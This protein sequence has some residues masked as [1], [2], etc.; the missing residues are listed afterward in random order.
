MQK[1]RKIEGEEERM[2]GMAR[3]NEERQ[4][5]KKMNGM[6]EKKEGRKKERKT[7]KKRGQGRKKKKVKRKGIWSR[8]DNIGY[9]YITLCLARVLAPLL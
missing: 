1:E 5:K 6:E 4:T 2:N 3:R 9:F 7:R 8:K